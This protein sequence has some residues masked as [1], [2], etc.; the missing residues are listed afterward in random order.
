ME[1][2]AFTA[3]V[4]PGGLTTDY[5]IKMLVCYMLYHLK[6]PVT[7]ER[8][9]Y[10]LQ[11]ENLVNY[12]ELAAAVNSLITSGSLRV[13][14]VGE[15]QRLVLGETGVETAVV[16]EKTLPLSV[17]E[18][19]LKSY[20]ENMMRRRLEQRNTAAYEKTEDG[21]EMTLT[22][23]DMGTDLL[24]MTLFVPTKARCE[25]IKRN[26]LHDPT[27]VYRAILLALTGEEIIEGSI[28]DQLDE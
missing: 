10:A 14:T 7:F 26:F 11:S 12:F 24:R 5:E 23:P 22:I 17:R 27:Q 18:Q 13:E 4:K 8:M 2:N 19:A 20:R 16:F 15:E 9:S 21:Y 3:G 25:E 28:Y 1:H 6:E